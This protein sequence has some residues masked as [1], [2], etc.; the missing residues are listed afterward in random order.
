V[1]LSD[2]ILSDVILSDVIL[3]DVGDVVVTHMLTHWT[4]LVPH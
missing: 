1:I 2:V 3:R 4:S